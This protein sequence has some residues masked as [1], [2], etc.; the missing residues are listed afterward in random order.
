MT[1]IN[2]PYGVTSIDNYTF[3]S[4]YELGN[5]N[6][7]SSVNSIG[8]EAFSGCSFYSFTIPDNVNFIGAGAFRN[9]KHLQKITI[10]EGVTSIE[11]STF[12]GCYGLKSIDI[13]EGVTSIGDYAFYYCYG[14][15]GIDI[16]NSVTSIG[17][18]AFYN[19]H[20]LTSITIPEGVTSI[21]RYTFGKCTYLLHIDIPEG[22]T[23]I[24]EYAFENDQFVSITIPSSVTRIADR[25]F[26][27]CYIKTFICENPTPPELG[28][29]AVFSTSAVP[30]IYT[31]C[32]SVEQYRTANYWSTY[33]DKINCQYT[34]KGGTWNFIAKFGDTFRNIF[35]NDSYICNN[36][37]AC[38][39]SYE[40]NNWGTGTENGDTTDYMY[41]ADQ[42][43]ADQ[44]YFVYPFD[45]DIVVIPQ[46]L[47]GETTITI[48]KTK[49]CDTATIFNCA[50]GNPFYANLDLP[51]D[52][53]NK[54]Q[55][56]TTAYVYDPSTKKWNTDIV[57]T[58]KPGQGFFVIGDSDSTTLNV[59]L[60]NP[61][62]T[63]SSK[64]STIKSMDN[65][66]IIFSA[67]A[68]EVARNTYAKQNELSENGFDV[69]DS[70]I[71]F[72]PNNT[73]LVE[74]YFVVD[75][76]DIL[77]NEFKTLP[78]IAPIN[79][80]AHNIVDVDFSASNVPENVSV[81]II[82][83]ADSTETDLTEGQVFSF[84]AEEGNNE[85]KYAIKFAQ[86]NSVGIEDVANNEV[87]MSLYPNPAKESTTLTINGLDKEATMTISDEL[88]R[89]IQKTTIAANETSKTINTSNLASGVYYIKIVNEKQTKT[90]KLIVR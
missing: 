63:T 10:P 17:Q 42:L 79:F 83:L 11:G 71:M 59:T 53:L 7:P 72:S 13:P 68:N 12:R 38:R 36:V 85:N 73:K 74:P 19:C 76:K 69:K 26:F 80:Y 40:N 47:T 60:T 61:N 43:Y 66:R 52:L 14:L 48:S 6:I 31:P 25:A 1:R 90:E 8:A 41:A 3:A 18:Y 55:G 49:A 46:L 54:I 87:S 15:N 70:Y 23:Y 2:I 22:V 35:N 5:L 27:S 57:T 34:L 88:G 65:N 21:Q 24:G 84:T 62:T 78:Y 37:V 30:D 82:N 33:A 56:Q 81:S 77:I 89:T 16:P 58:I 45:N 64:K 86:K 4:C 32:E 51:T 67:F 50:L 39:F 75:G 44:G 20:G 28:G 9:C 29:T